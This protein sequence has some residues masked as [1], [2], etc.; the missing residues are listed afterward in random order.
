MDS[1]GG[2]EVPEMGLEEWNKSFMS[3]KEMMKDLYYKNQPHED[4]AY[5]I[6]GGDGRD[7]FEPFSP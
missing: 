5:S 7:P 3:M 2:G 4:E 1:K 6:K